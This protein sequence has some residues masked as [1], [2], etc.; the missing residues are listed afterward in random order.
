MQLFPW[1]GSNSSHTESLMAK[2]LGNTCFSFW[3]NCFPGKHLLFGRPLLHSL[4]GGLS[5]SGPIAF[6]PVTT[7]LLSFLVYPPTTC[8][9]PMGPRATLPHLPSPI[10]R[11]YLTH[12]GPHPPPSLLSPHCPRRERLGEG[13]PWASVHFGWRWF[14]PLDATKT[15]RV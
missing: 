7:F 6:P 2:T 15:F 3:K 1:E 14:Q 13:H 9:P 12:S 4:L 5:P 11:A 8:L 10:G